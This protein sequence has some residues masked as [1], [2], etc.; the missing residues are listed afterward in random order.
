MTIALPNAKVTTLRVS[1]IA[2]LAAL[3]VTGLAPT[4][5][6]A[7]EIT[8]T[9]ETR[10]YEN[11]DQRDDRVHLNM[12]VSRDDHNWQNGFPIDLDEL[13]GLSV[14]DARGSATDASFRIDREAGS[15]AFDGDFRDG[16]GTGFFTFTPNA[17]YTRAMADLGY[18]DLSDDRV[19][20]FA[21]QRVSTDFVRDLQTL[22][23]RD[24][25]EDD[26]WKFAI[27]GVRPDYIRGMNDLG[28]ANID[29]GDLVRMRI[30]GVSVDYVR[31]V[32]AALR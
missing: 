8:G 7:Q 28:Y 27:H 13:Q 12:R 5:A 29:A 3:L 14:S 26:L 18:P 22:G 2:L 21:V 25:P 4:R 10:F 6:A 11:D 30:H 17:E 24:L 23:Y 16:R 15:I 20:M 19:L 9:W 1:A 32:R 31:A